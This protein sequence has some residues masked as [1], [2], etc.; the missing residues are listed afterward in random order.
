M[1]NRFGK[2][3]QEIWHNLA[4][5]DFRTALAKIYFLLAF[6]VLLYQE[7]KPCP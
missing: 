4:A 6:Y 3:D 1:S 7:F 5:D 2:G